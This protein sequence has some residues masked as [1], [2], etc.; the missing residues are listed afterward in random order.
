MSVRR[1]I[2]AHGINGNWCIGELDDTF[3]RYSS[4]LEIVGDTACISGMV[5]IPI[6][7]AEFDD[8]YTFF[9]SDERHDYGSTTTRGV[10]GSRTSQLE[11]VGWDDTDWLSLSLG[12]YD[13]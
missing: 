6:T 13:V 11:R 5:F 7:G 3:C 4:Y 9:I 8:G 1:G 2:P 12:E 10:N